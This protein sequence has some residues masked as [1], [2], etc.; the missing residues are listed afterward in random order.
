MVISKF[1]LK[2]RIK[3][4]DMYYE[5]LLLGSIAWNL[6]RMLPLYFTPASK[7]I[8]SNSIFQLYVK[9]VYVQG[10]F[11]VIHLDIIFV[12]FKHISTTS[13]LYHNTK[14]HLKS[15]YCHAKNCQKY[16]LLNHVEF[17]VTAL[18]LFWLKYK[19]ITVLQ[20]DIIQH[21]C[22]Q[23]IIRNVTWA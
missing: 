5:Q 18:I 3:V 17:V 1:T 12:T 22:L 13:S 9:S 15:K 2:E 4:W 19:S 10:N 8:I 16:I 7:E 23:L 21:S 14:H 6:S 11:D 20:K